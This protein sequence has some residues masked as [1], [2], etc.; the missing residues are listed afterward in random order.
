[1]ELLAGRY[2][3][4]DVLGRGGSGVVHAGDD[5]VL[6]RRVALK[7]LHLAPATADDDT[8]GRAL[9]EA[10]AAA[11]VVSPS[12][13]R[14]FDVVEDQGVVWVVMELVD[15]RGLDAVL[16]DGPLDPA[17]AARVGL[18]VLDALD[19]VHR[20]GLVHRDVKPGN[21]LVRPDG[22]VLLTDFG[23]ARAPSDPSLTVTGAIVGSPAY[24]CPERAAGRPA[25]PASDLWGLGAT[26]YA[27]VEGRPAFQREGEVPTLFAVLHDEPEL[28]ARSGALGPVIARMLRKDPL[29]RP[30]SAE[31]REWLTAVATGATPVLPGD[32]PAPRRR[33]PLLALL[34]ATPAVAAAAFVLGVVLHAGAG[35][36]AAPAQAAVPSPTPSAAAPAAVAVDVRPAAASTPAAPRSVRRAPVVRHPSAAPSAPVRHPAVQAPAPAHRGPARGPVRAP[37]RGK[38]AGPHP[39]KHGGH[40]GKH[41]GHPGGHGGGHPGKHGGGNGTA[42]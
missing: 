28:T 13:V 11:R 17:D 36:P 29:E 16:R 20:A 2:R 12:V 14:V 42:V 6:G 30:G 4:L 33:R 24:L 15:A 25:T 8:R 7:R 38:K 5:V 10:R 22:S 37:G 3:V 26:L 18:G 27:A 32:E 40:P 1:M 9:Q 19:A 39:G 35:G 21:I 41:P 23:I 34:A 31:V